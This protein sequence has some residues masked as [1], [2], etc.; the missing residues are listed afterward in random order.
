MASL[1]HGR[2]CAVL[3][4]G[5]ALLPLQSAQSTVKSF[6]R[7]SD[8]AGGFTARRDNRGRRVASGVYFYRLQVGRES[9]TRKMAMVQ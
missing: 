5:L 7:I 8:T 3:I 9:F 4:S 6:Q 1:S 2:C